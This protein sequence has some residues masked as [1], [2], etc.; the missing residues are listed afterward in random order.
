MKIALKVTTYKSAGKENTSYIMPSGNGM[1]R[2]EVRNSVWL[3]G[4]NSESSSV[5]NGLSLYEATAK[6]QVQDGKCNNTNVSIITDIEDWERENYLLA[7]AAVYNGNRY[8]VVTGKYPPM[9]H[10]EDGIGPNMETSITD[11]HHLGMKDEAASIELMSGDMATP[12]FGIY[13]KNK[14]LGMLIYSI[15]NTKAG[16]TG[17]VFKEKQDMASIEIQA[18]GVRS[19]K[20]G[21]MDSGLASD[22]RGYDFESGDCIEIPFK[23]YTFP[24]HDIPTLFQAFWETRK[25][26]NEKIEWKNILPFSKAFDII[27]SKY[28]ISQWNSQYGYYMVAPHDGGKY[29]DW[30]AG[31]VGGGINSYAF[32]TAGAEASQ[33]MAEETMTTI[34]SLLQAPNGYIY[35]MMFNGIL[36]GD[37]FCHQ[38]KKEV[39]LLRKN[40]DVLTFACK[41]IKLLQKRNK[42]VPDIW[43]KGARKLADAFVRL[44]EQYGQFGQFVDIHTE[45]II[46]GGTASAGIAVA[47]LA[48]A[49][50]IFGDAAYINTA[51]QAAAHYEDLY[52]QKGLLNGGPGEILQCPDSESA[53]GLLDGYVTLYEVTGDKRWV[54]S[55]EKCAHQ[56]C[57]W[58]VSYDFD[59]PGY[60]EYGRLQMKTTGSVYANVQNKHSAPGICTL[61]PISLF[62]LYRIT[63]HEKYLEL[64]REISHNVTQYLSRNDRPIMSWDGEELPAGWMCERVNMSD[65]E[66]K[67][68]IGGVFKGS[69]WCEISSLLTYAEI[70]GIWFLRDT[71]R[72]VVFD[73]AA[74]KVIDNGD[75]WRLIIRNDTGFDA[76][77][78]LYEENTEDFKQNWGENRLE[79]CRKIFAAAGDT[80]EVVINKT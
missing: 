22:D 63:G 47:G 33:R 77:I 31:W 54:T 40:A 72:A 73:H 14:N 79:G 36:L 66:G 53:F 55:A 26:M 49:Y 75:K 18:P 46:M 12:C 80:V 42:N 8:K 9:I 23:I 48:L 43:A 71:G 50:D 3:A 17:F 60:S 61:S 64:C 30:Q 76:E 41:H 20:Y 13:M 62:K 19:K 21:M 27:Q 56:C 51:V 35:P 15:H 24:C 2:L 78:K 59:F 57:S 67:E 69:C 74:A 38:D 34:F 52:I 7:P 68:N 10:E 45:K 65:W 37:D 5:E 11:V 70:P 25:C 32:L 28:M 6:F 1:N 39:L 58:C 16:Y 4:I 29:G 44:W